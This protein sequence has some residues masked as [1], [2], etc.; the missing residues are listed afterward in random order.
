MEGETITE[1]S[2]QLV[3]LIDRLENA[4]PDHVIDRD[5]MLRDQLIENVREPY[6]RWELKKQVAHEPES[7][8]IA[9]RET[10]IQWSTEMETKKKVRTSSQIVDAKSMQS[11]PQ[12][13]HS[14]QVVKMLTE[15]MAKQ[16][17]RRNCTPTARVG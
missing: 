6:L 5:T 8:F 10:A 13:P 2:H 12:Q 7:T 4:S 1:Y 3:Q 16:P 11:L 15:M 17:H 9:C 14:D